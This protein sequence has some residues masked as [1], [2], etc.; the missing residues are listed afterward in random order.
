MGVNDGAGGGL[1]RVGLELR[2]LRDQQDHLEQVVEPKLLF[3]RDLDQRHLAPELLDRHSRVR[4]LLLD[5]LG[6]GI[7]LIDLVEGDDDG[8]VRSANVLDCL[9]GLGHHAI[10]GRDHQNGDV[11][12]LCSPC[13]HRGEG[14]VPRRVDEC[15]PLAVLLHLVGANALGD[16]ARLAHRNPRLADG[17]ED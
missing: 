8:H 17:V 6:V 16:T 2:D 12:H 9:G 1:A 13:S 11:G 10:V 7:V 5:T 4:E 15:D 14:F 3:G